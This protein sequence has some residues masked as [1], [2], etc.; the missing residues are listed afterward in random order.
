VNVDFSYSDTHEDLKTLCADILTDFSDPERFKGLEA[1]GPYF[2]KSLWGKLQETGI[3]TASF[4]EALGG[5]DMDYSATTLVAELLGQTV[6]SIPYI[7]CVVSTALPLISGVRDNQFVTETLAR[8]ASGETLLVPGFI[9][10]HNEEPLAPNTIVKQSGD[11]YYID[12]IKHC[13]PY[14][15]DAEAVLVSGQIDGDLWLGLVPLEQAGVSLTEQR[16]TSNEPQYQVTMQQAKA[17]CVAQGNAARTLIE[18]SVAMTTAA[19]CSMAVGLVQRMTK[20]SAEYTSQREQFGVPI[21]TFQA[22]A[23]R[24]ASCYID[25]ECLRI[26]TLKAASDI[27]NG[28]F[29][30]ESLSMAK[31]WCGDVCHR[32]SQAAQHV[33]GGIGIDKNYHLFRYCL[34]AK[35]LELSLGSSKVHIA[36]LADRIEEKYLAQASI[37][38]I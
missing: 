24:L 9:E 7:P 2:D 8:V 22:V 21:A 11:H 36:Q 23:H 19:Y 33:H 27:N 18:Q 28:H 31:A 5:M 37:N 13:V 25:T 14:A 20:I 1:N 38:S 32:I 35:Q 34:W 29:D 16:C 3:L 17:Q 6:V 4:P 10:P 30:E 12:G 15:S 26:I